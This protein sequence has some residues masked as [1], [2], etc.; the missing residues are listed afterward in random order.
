MSDNGLP[1]MSNPRTSVTIDDWPIGRQRCRARFWIERKAGKGERACR[2]TENK[3]RTGWNKPKRA[4]YARRCAIVD[5]D[6]GRTYILSSGLGSVL[7]MQGDMK[8]SAGYVY[9]EDSQYDGLRLL[10]DTRTGDVNDA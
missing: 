2:I 7:V 6:D 3:T 1:T 5:G 9:P 4:T 8:F 10:L